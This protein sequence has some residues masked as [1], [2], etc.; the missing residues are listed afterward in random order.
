MD[1][2]IYAF[3]G[4]VLWALSTHIDKYL[5]ERYFKQ[6]SVAVLMVFTAIIGVLALP[7]IWLFQ[8]GVVALDYESM[9]VI[10][11]SGILYMGAI[12]FYLQALQTEEAST[13]APFFQAAGVFGLILGYFVLGEQVSNSQIIGVLLIIAGSVILS[14]RFGQ[15]T[16]HVKKQL[17]IL[18]LS[19][20]LAISLSS[21]IFKFF[22]VRDEFWTTTFW[23][24]FGQALFGVILMLAAKNRKQF[25]EMIH[26]N[27]GALLSVN[28]T[29]ELINLGGNLAVRYTLLLAPL[30][31]VQAISS[32]TSFFVLFFGVILSL[33]FPNFARKEISIGSLMQKI[34][35]TTFVVAGILLI[36]MQ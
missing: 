9:A 12:Y 26:A 3:S 21:L 24:F 31:V 28:I 14:L 16:S 34:I 5:V 17:V 32:T 25:S 18:M 8:P 33:F 7:F 4:P 20:A 1:W 15:G 27:A 23:N 10:A 13:I 2:L 30:G 22:A 35:A 11:A 29:N 36:N 6:G 19:C